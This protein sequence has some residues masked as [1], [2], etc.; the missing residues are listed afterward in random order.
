MAIV[1]MPQRTLAKVVESTIA[2]EEKMSIR[3][4]NMARYCQDFDSDEYDELDDEEQVKPNRIG[5]KVW[6]DTYRRGV[7]C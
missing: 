4:R 3:K 1:G 2:I 6:F 5:A 7:Y